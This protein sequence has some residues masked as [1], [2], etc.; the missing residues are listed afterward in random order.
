MVLQVQ[1]LRELNLRKPPQAGRPAHL[2]AA[3]GLVRAGEFLYV[4]ADDEHHLGV[5]PALGNERGS[6]LRLR[7]GD[8]PDSKATRKALKPDLEALALL[9]AF[10]D[11][12]FGALLAV[13][14]GSR[15]NRR[16]G[17][18]MGLDAQGAVSRTP[19]ML[20]LAGIFA[21]IADRVDDINI[22]GA[23]IS[24]ER[25]RLLQRGNKGK[26]RNA[27]IDFDLPSLLRS[28]QSSSAAAD[29]RLLEI[30]WFDLGVVE[31]VPLSFSD[32][33]TLADGS[34]IFT[35]IA[36]DT[37]D[38]Y[39]DGRCVGAAIGIIDT[40]G[41]LQ[42]LQRLAQPLKI[43]GI[44]AHATGHVIRLLLVTDADDA[45]IPASLYSAELTS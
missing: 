7:P 38:S 30:S 20:D 25:L 33:A 29:A 16:A 41:K 42:R 9:P 5:F 35:A 45:S 23:T 44:A 19:R 32:G 8:L 24:G 26:G 2:S 28:L 34:L 37:D 22:E 17:F 1:K 43:E 13:G 15:P 14:S 36:E 27:V 18:L 11:H 21:A 10:T 39:A 12:P 31:G 6:L 3:S 4:V 40:S